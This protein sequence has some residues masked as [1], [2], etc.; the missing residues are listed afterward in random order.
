MKFREFI[1]S[2]GNKI[3]LGKNAKNNDEL[4]K[5]FYEKENIILHTVAPGSPFCVIENLNP[6][7]KEIKEAAIACASKSQNWR[8]N[9]QDVKVSVFSGKEVKKEKGMKEGTWGVKKKS[10]MI[11]VK[12]REIEDFMKCNQ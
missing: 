10:K 11:N 5:K 7:K 4:I 3:F 8:D 9:R 2:S 1:S 12:K 6:T